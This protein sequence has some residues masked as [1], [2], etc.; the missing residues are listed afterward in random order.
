VTQADRDEAMRHPLVRQVA[1]LFD[2]KLV[3]LRPAKP[4]PIPE[5]EN[6]AQEEP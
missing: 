6:E 5:P 2:A 1:D 3:D 4:L